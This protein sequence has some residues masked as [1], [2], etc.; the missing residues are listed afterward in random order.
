MNLP[1]TICDLRLQR[2]PA[3]ARPSNELKAEAGSANLPP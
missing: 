3:A 2:N 1:F